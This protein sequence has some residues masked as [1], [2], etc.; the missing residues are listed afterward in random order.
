MKAVLLQTQLAPQ[1]L[2]QPQGLSP[3]AIMVRAPQLATPGL[4]PATP[5]AAD[6]LS[7]D[8]ATRLPT[9]RTDW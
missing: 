8:S 6:A 4:S 1:L 5:H 3:S 7:L 9:A 2:L